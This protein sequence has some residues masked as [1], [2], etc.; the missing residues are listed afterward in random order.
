MRRPG[1]TA[2]G[3]TARPRSG[4]IWVCASTSCSPPR[5]SAAVAALHRSNASR[6]RGSVRPI[7][8]PSYWKSKMAS[9]WLVS[10]SDSALEE[11]DQFLRARAGEEDMLLD[12][13]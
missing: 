13:V 12:G 1:T 8:H 5:R 7:T 10:P 9:D 11:L 3:T 2:G 4:A 6:A